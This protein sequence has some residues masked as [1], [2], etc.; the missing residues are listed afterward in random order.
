MQKVVA[1]LFM[2]VSLFILSG[3]TLLWG[4]S[5]YEHAKSSSLMSFLYPK[6]EQARVMSPEIPVLNLPLKVGIAFVPN[7]GNSI[8]PSL[9]IKL[10]EQ[11]KQ[12]F[13]GH[14]Y[15]QNIEI[16]PDT[17]LKR[18][19]GFDGL[20]Q[21]SRLYD[22]DVMALVSYDQVFSSSENKAAISYLTIVGMFLIPGNDNSTQTFVDTAV[23]DIKSRKLLFRAPGA[24]KISNSS[25]VVNID[26]V[27]VKNEEKSFELA[28]QDMNRNLESELSRFKERVKN[29]KVATIK[30]R[31]GYSGG[32]F[33]GFL[34]CL[35]L[36]CF[37]GIRRFKVI[38]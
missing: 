31:E 13:K 28:V 21:V 9:Q 1:K 5:N 3:C 7:H 18:V 35:L 4:T 10:L 11:V 25:S 34:L 22:L 26:E 15:I 38:I 36:L 37:I 8:H 14:Q 33:T 17:Y 27:R 23:F 19:S 2:V 20:D 30:H 29:E 24:N 12:T 6:K 32:G 16:I